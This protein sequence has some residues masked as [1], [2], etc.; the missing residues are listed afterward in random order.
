M[1]RLLAEWFRSGVVERIFI[2][3]LVDD[4]KPYGLVRNNLEKRPAF[5]AVKHLLSALA[6]PGEPFFPKA[7][8]CTLSGGTAD[9][10]SLVL[11]KR[12]GEIDLLLWQEVPSW[13]IETK[14]ELKPEPV[15]ITVTFP[16]AVSGDIVIPGQ[17]PEPGRPGGSFIAQNK[18][19][20]SVPD[21]IL[22]IRIK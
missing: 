4:V 10:H 22:I 6:D 9:I 11:G 20:I 19:D 2:Y 18:I 7:F 1:P 5:F 15:R 17:K 21:E 12:N 14:Q 8:P 13:N 16:R 3:S